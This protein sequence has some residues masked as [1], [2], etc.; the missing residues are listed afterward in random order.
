MATAA[1]ITA[2]S[3]LSSPTDT[4]IAL[5]TRRLAA[6]A[7]PCTEF[8]RRRIAPPPMKPMPVISPSTILAMAS[9]AG[10][11]SGSVA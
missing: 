9:G 7:V 5:V 10:A 11:T 8:S 4:P 6:V 3:R 1:S 2:T